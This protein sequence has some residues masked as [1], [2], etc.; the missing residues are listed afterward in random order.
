MDALAYYVWSFIGEEERSFITLTL[1]SAPPHI[2]DAASAEERIGKQWN[3]DGGKEGATTVSTMTLYL[4][5]LSI[6][7][8]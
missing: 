6:M 4:T 1:G 8:K 5:A 7:V 2:Y 3:T